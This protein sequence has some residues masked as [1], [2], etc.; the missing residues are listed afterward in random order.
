MARESLF[1]RWSD[2][3]LSRLELVFVVIV[4]L[5]LVSMFLNYML[6]MMARAER[7]MVESSII[8]MNSA[9]RVQALHALANNGG[10]EIENFRHANPVA[11]LE[12][13]IDWDQLEAK[14]SARVA[15][16]V[17]ARNSA[18]LPNYAGELT[19]EAGMELDPGSWYF[20]TEKDAL[21]Y[22][23][24][25]AEVFRSELPGP[26]RLRY[27]LEIGAGGNPEQASGATIGQIRLQ[28]MDKYQWLF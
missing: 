10:S 27:Q 7:S 9:L 24:R 19:T 13:E 5:V 12:R 3:R 16:L 21:V 26:A 4:L 23:V 15:T 1:A 28:P 6:V 17:R 18:L 25:N 11:L 2:H 22:L 20:D 8:N 14:D